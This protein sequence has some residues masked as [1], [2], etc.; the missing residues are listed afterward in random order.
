M[1][2]NQRFKVMLKAAS[3]MVLESPFIAKSF[4]VSCI[5]IAEKFLLYTVYRYNKVNRYN[6]EIHCVVFINNSRKQKRG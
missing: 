6:K 5:G 4:F 2:K 3:S 1:C